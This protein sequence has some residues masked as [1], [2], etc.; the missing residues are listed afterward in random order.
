MPLNVGIIH[1]MWSIYNCV[2]LKT[3]SPKKI[4]ST[5]PVYPTLFVSTVFGKIF[6]SRS[7]SACTEIL[8]L[9]LDP[10]V[11]N[12]IERK[13]SIQL[14]K[15]QI[16]LLHHTYI[17]VYEDLKIIDPVSSFAHCEN[18]QYDNANNTMYR[19]DVNRSLKFCSSD[20]LCY[21]LNVRKLYTTIL[22]ME[23]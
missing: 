20:P 16:V 8:R 4:A 15:L 9:T 17:V 6:K 12:W 19:Y 5:C 13:L 7:S 2:T 1:D 18:Y 23:T 3:E 22:F 10:V 14:I 21:I 11:S